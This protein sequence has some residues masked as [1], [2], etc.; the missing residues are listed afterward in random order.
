MKTSTLETLSATWRRVGTRGL[1]PSLSRQGAQP[2]HLLEQTRPDYL[3]DDFSKLRT[4][5]VKL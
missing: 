2:N 1:F 5:L 4:L 3:I